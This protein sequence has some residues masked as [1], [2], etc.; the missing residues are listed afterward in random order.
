MKMIHNFVPLKSL[1]L[2]NKDSEL[3]TAT[4]A[5]RLCSVCRSPCK[6][7]CSVCSD[8]SNGIIVA[9]CGLRSK[10]LSSKAYCRCCSV[11]IVPCIHIQLLTFYM[12]MYIFTDFVAVPISLHN[13]PH[14]GSSVLKDHMNIISDL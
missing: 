10:H 8:A 4:Y 12:Y 7:C 11:N 2:Y 14:E 6:N 3:C 5:S 9:L 1:P 13:P